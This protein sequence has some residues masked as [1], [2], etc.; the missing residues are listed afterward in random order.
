MAL[1]EAHFD[2]SGS[3]DGPPV[4]CVAGYLYDKEAALDLDSEWKAV[5]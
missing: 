3:H 5:S 1:F 4:L 2:E